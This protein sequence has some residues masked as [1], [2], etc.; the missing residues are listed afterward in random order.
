MRW[1]DDER[2]CS[3]ELTFF[4]SLVIVFAFCERATAYA[5]VG[6]LTEPL[7]LISALD[8]L[9]LPYRNADSGAAMSFEPCPDQEID[10][11]VVW[12]PD[13]TGHG[14]NQFYSRPTG[15]EGLNAVVFD[16]WIRED[17]LQAKEF[18]K[19]H[20]ADRRAIFFAVDRDLFYWSGNRIH[21]LVH[22]EEVPE[23]KFDSL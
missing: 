6:R 17:G 5:T 13:E 15:I 9:C 21:Q 20:R 4:L 19:A 11:C 12:W 10:Q 3:K 16:V 1:R 2:R 7:A 14:D 22:C 18:L 23:G 8:G